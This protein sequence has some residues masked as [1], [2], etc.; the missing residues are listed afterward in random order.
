[1]KQTSRKGSNIIRKST[2]TMHLSLP[3]QCT[4]PRVNPNVNY[5]PCVI[6]MCQC[7]F[8]SYNKCIA[9]VGHVNNGRGDGYVGVSVMGNLCTSLLILL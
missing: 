3:I 4:T 9:L 6:M 8:L 7:S 5:G 1:M 2:L